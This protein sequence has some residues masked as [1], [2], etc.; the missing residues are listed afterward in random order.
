MTRNFERRIEVEVPIYD[1]GLKKELIDYINIQFQDN[2][3]ARVIN[4]AQDNSERNPGGRKRVRSQDAIYRYLE[5]K[6]RR[7]EE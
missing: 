1:E 4:A 2:V 7:G 6:L 5:G 3:K